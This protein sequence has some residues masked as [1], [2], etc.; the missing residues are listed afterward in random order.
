[1]NKE[2]RLDRFVTR[3]WFLTIL[4]F[5]VT[6]GQ[7]WENSILIQIVIVILLLLPLISLVITLLIM[8]LDLINWIYK[9][10]RKDK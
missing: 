1:M 4:I 2:T 8:L 10:V 5:M 9:K 7:F 6:I 3:Y